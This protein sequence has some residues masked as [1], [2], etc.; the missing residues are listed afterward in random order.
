MTKKT[1]LMR[2][3]KSIKSLIKADNDTHLWHFSSVG[4]VNRVNLLSGTDI[5]S[6]DQLDQKLWTALSCPVSGLEI[7][8]VTLGLIDTD[9][10]KRIRVPEVLE[11]IKWLTPLVKNLDDLIQEKKSLPLSSINDQTKEGKELLRCVKQ[12]LIN[13]G[14]PDETEITV[15]ETS[16]FQKIFAT[17][18]FNG[19]GIITEDSAD[20]EELKILIK[21]IISCMNSVTDR[22][23]KPGI[24]REIADSFFQYCQDYADWYKIS[25]ENS[26]EILPFGEN[27]GMA[28][29]AF[30]A[31][32]SKI[33]DY[34]LRCRLTE[35]D[36]AST[37]ILGLLKA[38]YEGISS[39]NLA[40]CTDEIA[41]L[42][43]AKM[44]KEKIMPLE[45]AINPSWEKALHKFRQLVIV[46]LFSDKKFITADEWE[47]IVQKIEGYIKWMSLKNGAVVEKLGLS[48]V[49]E[50]LEKS[51]KEELLSLIEKDI[52]LKDEADN[53]YKVDRLTR[54]YCN[55]FKLLKNYVNFSDF[56]S[57]DENAIFQA[58]KLFIDQRCCD[59]CIRVN[60]M[61]KHYTIAGSSGIC[62]LYCNCVS[63]VKGETMTIVAA[64]TDGDIDNITVGRN[65]IFY[66]RQGIDWDATI[67]KIIDNPI[68]IRQA[69]WS[70]YRKFSR[71]ISSQV[72]KFASSKEKAVG[73]V[74]ESKAEKITSK[75][76]EGITG[77]VQSKPVPASA[78]T[79]QPFDIGKF[80]GIF[81]A[82]SLALGAIGSVIMSALTGFFKL[83]WWQMP[84]AII[85][86]VLVI[87]LP[88]MLIAWLKLRKRNL[89]PVLDANGWAINARITVNIIFGRTLTHLAS[90]P[91][92]SK[93]DL[94]DP[95]TKKKNPWVPIIII[96]IIVICISM[97]LLRYFGLIEK[98]GLITI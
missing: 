57:S 38:H 72:E 28:L 22:N 4:G 54:Y 36:P 66:D 93:V 7:D 31:V 17:T 53:V 37:E 65:A 51:K 80:V 14:K 46:P 18:G 63:K 26:S 84:V 29:E 48:S 68:S 20:N 3:V 86:I 35:Y 64:L 42:P 12:I 41:L 67:I 62:L 74:A 9:G 49:T 24:N 2:P 92:N 11:A 61:P 90:L 55:L 91:E 95:F 78:Q 87:S 58:G 1:R 81:A 10:D 23:G 21:N 94:L 60:D 69:F 19:D 47:F 98:W 13:L 15:N 45:G 16:D 25:R 77:Y 6:L 71:F 30:L 39:K 33:D 75:V 76:D 89:A 44:T 97:F 5:S 96:A 59:L 83:R 8:S 79:Q 73:N 56:Y 50:I 43:I 52:E 34:F 82:L 88:S 85:G 27:T 70:P 32:K 40:T